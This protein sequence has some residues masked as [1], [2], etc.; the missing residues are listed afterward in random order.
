MLQ[1]HILVNFYYWGAEWAPNH[2]LSVQLIFKNFITTSNSIG[3]LNYFTF[4][5]TK[6]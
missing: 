3:L 1:E 5:N 2:S 4:S 6:L